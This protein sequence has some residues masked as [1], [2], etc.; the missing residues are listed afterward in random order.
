VVLILRKNENTWI[1]RE[2]TQKNQKR[3]FILVPNIL[4]APGI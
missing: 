3:Q 2:K 1:K 4:G